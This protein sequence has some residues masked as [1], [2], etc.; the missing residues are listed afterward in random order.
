MANIYS[1]RIT[2]IKI[3]NI[4]NVEYITGVNWEKIGNDEYGNFG[5]IAGNLD[6]A[7]PLIKSSTTKDAIILLIQ[8]SITNDADLN[9]SIDEQIESY[10]NRPIVG[11]AIDDINPV[12]TEPY[13]PPTPTFEELKLTAINNIEIN[14]NLKIAQGCP[15]NGH[16]VAID[17][18]SL[19]LLNGSVLMAN[20]GQWN[21]NK[22]KML[23]N[24]FVTLTSEELISMATTVGAYINSLYVREEQIRN[25]L[26]AATTEAELEYNF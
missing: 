16:I 24:T 25:Q 8:Q 18:A 20:L 5:M 14:K 7:E 17:N 4:D 9:L 11:R 26:N 21:N 2:N 12:I 23:D 13:V 19:N 3:E 1:F 22:W 10:K 6:L 15:W